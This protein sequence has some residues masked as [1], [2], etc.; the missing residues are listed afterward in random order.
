MCLLVSATPSGSA[1]ERLRD[2]PRVSRHAASDNALDL[3]ARLYP[4]YA[5]V[6]RRQGVAVAGGERREVPIET[7]VGE[8]Y[9]VVAV[10]T[11]LSADVDLE[12]FGGER[13]IDNDLSRDL[14][15]HVSWCA[16]HSRSRVEV[17]AP[18]ASADVDLVVV[19]SWNSG[20]TTMDGE[21][22]LDALA[23]AAAARSVPRGWSEQRVV[24]TNFDEPGVVDS[25]LSTGEG[26]RAWVAVAENSVL[27]HDLLL[28][29][30]DSTVPDEETEARKGSERS[31]RDEGPALIVHCGEAGAPER[32]L[33]VGVRRGS[34]TVRVSEYRLR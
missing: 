3:A 2:D 8:C 13:F 29:R 19:R 5:M 18:F 23:R 26:C 32:P 34:G 11:G 20:A 1:Q 9:A 4:N 25:T 7:R 28:E 14:P 15:A 17:S 21:G 30:G 27:D 22:P 6:G 16:E 31:M 12:M 33:L 10:D 24:D